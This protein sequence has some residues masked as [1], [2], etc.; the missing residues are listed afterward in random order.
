MMEIKNIVPVKGPRKDGSYWY[1]IQIH[2]QTASGKI[3]KKLM[4]I[5]DKD[6]MIIGLEDKDFENFEKNK[7]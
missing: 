1:G 4:F 7:R 3:Y 2:F 6:N 5:D